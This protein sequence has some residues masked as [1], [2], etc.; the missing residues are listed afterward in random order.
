MHNTTFDMSNVRALAEWQVSDRWK[1]SAEAMFTFS[2]DIEV[3]GNY[4]GTYGQTKKELH[5]L[6]LYGP[7]ERKGACHT[8]TVRPYYTREKE[9]NYS[10]QFLCGIV[11]FEAIFQNMGLRMQDSSVST[12]TLLSGKTWGCMTTSQTV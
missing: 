10:G 8:L 3:R 4:W 7:L 1:A 11:N 12:V 2:N 5:R 9:P 6:N